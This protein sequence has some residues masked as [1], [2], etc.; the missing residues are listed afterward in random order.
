MAAQ[1]VGRW[2]EWSAAWKAEL[3]AV[4]LVGYWVAAKADWKA[5]KTAAQMEMNS[6]EH[7]V[8]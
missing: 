3:K 7:W 1:W 6:A 4:C 5:V 2:V 8:D